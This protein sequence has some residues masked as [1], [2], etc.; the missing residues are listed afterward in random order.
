MLIRASGMTPT[1]ALVPETGGPPLE[2]PLGGPLY[3]QGAC[4]AVEPDGWRVTEAF[5]H[6]VYCCRVVSQ[7]EHSDGDGHC[8]R[9]R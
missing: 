2:G 4:L 8:S 9:R 3:E 5:V 1:H 6:D 7:E